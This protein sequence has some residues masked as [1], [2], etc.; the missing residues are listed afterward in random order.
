MFSP[1]LL[2][3]ITIQNHN[4]KQKCSFTSCWFTTWTFL[5][6]R[7]TTHTHTHTV[8]DNR[9][10]VHFYLSNELRDINTANN[11]SK[12]AIINRRR[13]IHTFFAGNLR[14]IR[15]GLEF[16]SFKIFDT[17]V[18]VRKRD[19][20]TLFHSSLNGEFLG[21]SFHVR[22]YTCD[23]RLHWIYLT[24]TVKMHLFQGKG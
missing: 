4:A 24:G 15:K 5:A 21:W 13:H 23:K 12:I 18:N 3:W 10:L 20:T 2:A 1:F 8:C 17:Y 9:M 22:R 7:K 19:E 6:K 14:R 16:E 11:L